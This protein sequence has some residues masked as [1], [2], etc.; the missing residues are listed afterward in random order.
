MK[1]RFLKPIRFINKYKDKEVKIEVIK[2]ENFRYNTKYII[3]LY[4]GNDYTKIFANYACIGCDGLYI[5]YSTFCLYRKNNK[6]VSCYVNPSNQL[7]T[8]ET[9]CLET[10]TK[11]IGIGV[12]LL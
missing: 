7:R 6:I 9:I 11:L 5:D 12:P 3:I 1:K 8:Y 10:V 4:C 2:A